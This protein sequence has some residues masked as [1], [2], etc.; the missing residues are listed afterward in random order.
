MIPIP[1]QFKQLAAKL[2]LHRE[3]E[4]G[5]S[6]HPKHEGPPRLFDIDAELS[7]IENLCKI[8]DRLSQL[9]M[10][11]TSKIQLEEL[12]IK[13]ELLQQSIEFVWARMHRFS[14]SNEAIRALAKA[15]GETLDRRDSLLDLEGKP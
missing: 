7:T 10:L 2:K 5:F 12:C 3:L 11:P 9:K 8:P 4:H 1:P 15:R 13:A 6:S 14:N